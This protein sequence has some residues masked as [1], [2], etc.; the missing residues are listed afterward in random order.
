[1]PTLD[2][3]MFDSLG[4]H[5]TMSCNKPLKKM[6]QS[7]ISTILLLQNAIQN[8]YAKFTFEDLVKCDYDNLESIRDCKLSIY[9]QEK[10]HTKVN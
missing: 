2:A 10:E 6:K 4:R 9:N 8:D 3:L 5:Y 7:I 1:M